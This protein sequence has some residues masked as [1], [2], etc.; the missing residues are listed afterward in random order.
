VAIDDPLDTVAIG[1]QQPP[2][3]PH[4]EEQVQVMDV[5]WD[6]EFPDVAEY[7]DAMRQGKHPLMPVLTRL[8]EA[9]MKDGTSAIIARLEASHLEIKR[10]VE[11]RVN[12]LRE[13]Q[14]VAPEMPS[15][16]APEFHN[17]VSAACRKRIIQCSSSHHL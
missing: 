11:L 10:S 16:L 4:P 13:A 15:Y 5:A 2:E 3:S 6:E 17:K 7:L 8:V 9:A 12:K 1:F 14:T